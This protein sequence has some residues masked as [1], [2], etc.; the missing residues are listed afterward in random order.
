MQFEDAQC[1]PSES[2]FKTW[3]L[4][5]ITTPELIEYKLGLR[6]E[7]IVSHWIDLEPSLNLLAKNLVVHDGNRTIGEF[8]LIVEN[9]GPIG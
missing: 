3:N 9:N 2:W 6:F 1:W 4:A 7:A 8:D 5:S